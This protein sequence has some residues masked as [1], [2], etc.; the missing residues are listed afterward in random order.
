MESAE[1]PMTTTITVRSH[2]ATGN[3]RALWPTRL[4]AGN[5]VIVAVNASIAWVEDANS[6]RLCVRVI[7][8]LI[9]TPTATDTGL[10]LGM[11]LPTAGYAVICAVSVKYAK[12]ENAYGHRILLGTRI[13]TGNRLELQMILPTA[14]NAGVHALLA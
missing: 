1:G 4:T 13:A 14:G 11:I 3:L 12:V 5:A 10:T 2:I 8:L 9:Q 7:L 6:P